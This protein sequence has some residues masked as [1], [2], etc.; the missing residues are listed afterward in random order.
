MVQFIARKA[1]GHVINFGNYDRLY[2][3]CLPEIG[4]PLV[5]NS[6][7]NVTKLLLAHVFICDY[8]EFDKDLSIG[9]DCLSDLYCGVLSSHIAPYVTTR[10]SHAPL[11]LY[12]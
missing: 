6:F 5:P 11:Q 8:E 9:L 3:N 10:L 1:H 7:E 2:A 4:F 12:V